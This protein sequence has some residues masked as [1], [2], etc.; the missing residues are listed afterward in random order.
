MRN[1]FWGVLLALM[2]AAPL[3]GQSRE[4]VLKAVAETSSW[5]PADQPTTYDEK[6]IEA[7]AGRR[8]PAII[9]YG[10]IG[11]TR[12]NWKGS[13]GNVRLTLYEMVDA[14]AAYGLF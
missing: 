3:Q 9:R 7:L 6:N 13:E 10:F 12:Q 4:S 14:T 2:L 8:G 1:A 5:T 11:A